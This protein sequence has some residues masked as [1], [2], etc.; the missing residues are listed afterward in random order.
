MTDRKPDYEV[1]YGKPPAASRFKPGRSGNPNGRPK[2]AK[3]LATD[4]AEEL[5]ETI[6]IREGDRELRVSKQRAMLKALVAK[7]LKG[8]ARAASLLITLVAKATAE[9]DG[10]PAPADAPLADVD[11]QILDDFLARGSSRPVAPETAPAT[12]SGPEDAQ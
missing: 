5:G 3:N 2:G 1:G 4:L 12:G 8:D 7:A 11:R 6:R 10:A 9:A